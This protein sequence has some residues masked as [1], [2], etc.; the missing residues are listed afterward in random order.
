L[1]TFKKITQ[2][3]SDDMYGSLDEVWTKAELAPCR[4]ISQ[5]CRENLPDTSMGE[6]T[7]PNF[8]PRILSYKKFAYKEGNEKGDIT[9]V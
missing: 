6:P 5:F 8:T 7:A 4:G 3:I 1:E 9:F 2:Q